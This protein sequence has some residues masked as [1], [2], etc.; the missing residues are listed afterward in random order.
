MG[1]AIFN[2]QRYSIHDGPGVRT[3]VFLKG[4]PLRCKWCANPESAKAKAQI[5]YNKAL[6]TDCGACLTGCPAGAI[7]RDGIFGRR[8]D[9][10]KCIQCGKCVRLCPANA[11]KT[12]G[13][14]A[15]VEEI[16]REVCK[17]RVFYRKSGGGVTLSGGEPFAQPD[18]AC[19]L[20]RAFKEK[21][22]STAAETTGAV[23]FDAIEKSLD[24]TD[25]FL[26]DVKHMDDAVHKRYTGAS[27]ERILKNL[28]RIN[29]AQKRIWIRVPLISGVNDTEE[30]MDRTVALAVSLSGVE[31]VELLPYHEY[32]VGKYAQLGLKYELEGMKPP[33]ASHIQSMVERLMQRYPTM[34]IVIRSHS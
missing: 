16:V 25:L 15:E 28:D 24:A 34:K 5:A 17:D 9:D 31:R 8:I 3:L 29:S 6:C 20:L 23:P 1:G 26:Y 14:I 32:G 19:E 18:F 7:Q 13:R 12:V 2:I 11:L 4:C 33:D 30:N 27:N 10:D 21:R 22:I